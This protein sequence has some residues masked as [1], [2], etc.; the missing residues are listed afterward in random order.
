MIILDTN[1][2][3]AL[4]R[5]GEHAAPQAWL[6]R[7]PRLSVW[8]TAV[9]LYEIEFGIMRLAPGRRRDEMIGVA[10]SI[11]EGSLGN[12]IAPFD[13][14][15]ARAAARIMAERRAAGRAIDMRDTFIAG[16]ALS[17]RAALATRNVRHFADLGVPVVNPW[18]R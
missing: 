15:A 2:I 12:R 9:T 18:L 10:A 4:M 1:V 5:P 14:A 3:G 8:T 11:I 17:H 16:I 13:A 6:D 7:Q